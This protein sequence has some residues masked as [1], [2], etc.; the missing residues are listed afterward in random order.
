[1]RADNRALVAVLVALIIVIS[2]G[3]AVIILTAL[4][5]SLPVPV[6]TTFTENATQTWLVHFSVSATGS[7]LVGAWTAYDGSG[8]PSL[9]VVDGTV[10]RPPDYVYRCPLIQP[11]TEYNGSLD[12]AVDSGPHTLFW[13]GCFA[14]SRVVITEA[15]QLV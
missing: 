14:A 1:M 4:P 12:V 6:G 8:F 5:T 9:V 2:I 3:G 10:G 13:S 15:V 7:R 11:W